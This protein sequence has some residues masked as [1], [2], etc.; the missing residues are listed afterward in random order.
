MIPKRWRALITGRW[1]GSATLVPAATLTVQTNVLGPTPEILAYNAAH[2][3]PD[4]NTRDWWRYAGVNGA[5]IFMSPNEVEATDDLA[6]VGDGVT[7][8][9]TFLARKAALRADPL[10]TSY[11]NWPYFTNRYEVND[12]YPNNHIKIN[13]AFTELRKLGIQIC[14]QITASE[15]RLPIADANDWGGKWELWQHYYAQAFYLGREFDVQRFQMFNEPNHPNAGGLTAENHLMRLQL[16]ADAVQSALAD[17]NSRYGKSLL[18]QVLAPVSAGNATS[19]YPGWG[20]TVVT[21]RHLNFLGVT[22]PN[23]WLIQTYDYHQYGSTPAAFGSNLADLHAL[24]AADMTPEPR[25]PTAISEFNTRT[26]ASYDSIP[27][28]LD[29][30]AEYARFGAIA[31]NLMANG[32]A[33]MYA[34]KFGQTLSSYTNYPVQKNAMHYIDNNNA[35]YNTGGITKAGEVYRLFNKAFAAGRRRLNTIK[36]SGASGLDVHA[37]FDPVRNCYHLFSANNTSSALALNLSLA[38]LNLP[39]TNRVLLEEVSEKSYGSG[40]LWT[41]VSGAE[42]GL[43]TQPAYSVWL[44]TLPLTAQLAEQIVPATDDAEVRDGANKANNYGALTT[45][46][47]RN[48]PADTANRSVAFFK[49]QLPTNSLSDLQFAELSLQAASAGVNTTAQSHVYALTNT[50]WS[51]GGINWNNAPNLKGNVA[52]GNTIAHRFVTGQGTNASI[53]GQLVTTSTV[54]SEK[55]IDVTDY[56]RGQSNNTVAFLVS[57]DPRWDVALPS[58][59]TGDT[60]PAGVK[61]ITTEGGNGPRLRLVFAAPAPNELPVALNDCAATSRNIPVNINVLANDRDLDGGMLAIQSFT[62]GAFGSVSNA[63]SGV[64]TY[65]PDNGFTGLDAFSYTVNDGQGGAA[66]AAVNVTVNA[67]DGS[68][69]LVVT[70]LPVAIEANIQGGASAETD[71]NEV[72][73]GYLMLKY[74]AAPFDSARKVYFQ[75]D[76]TGLNVQVTNAATFSVTTHTMTF[77]QRAQLWGLNQ[78]YPGFNSSLTWNLAQANETNSNALL[79]NGV[80]HAS[81]IGDSVL[82]SGATSTVRSFTIPRLGD[83]LVGNHVT[84]ILSGVEDAGNASGGL[85]L[86]RNSARLQ[87]ATAVPA[88]NTSP[89]A[90]NDQFSTRE[91]TALSVAA[92]G[93][94]A[95]DTD[96]E[97]NALTAIL[98]SPPEQG[99]LTLSANGAF[100]YTPASGFFGNDSFA[101]KVSDGWVDSNIATVSLGV[102]PGG[103]RT[104]QIS[105]ISSSANGNIAIAF[106]GVP[107]ATYIVQATTNL[108]SSGWINLST[109]VAG[110]DGVWTFIDAGATQFQA[111][112]YRSFAP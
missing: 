5:R 58:L 4:S 20:D 69:I 18:A 15:G 12:L 34:F 42:A 53:V 106:L 40:A 91:N 67:G 43:G 100:V 28:T 10:N 29:Y 111:Q 31:V 56:L 39:P 24:L 13:Y 80:L 11:I 32:I 76:L 94:L 26:G 21:N 17:V 7:N 93:V 2:F 30:P 1:L 83:F 68:E 45:M 89:V 66:T 104:N 92:P 23:F 74:Y 101:Y 108:A 97:T 19:A 47:A 61:I 49:F 22:D 72:T 63:G 85:R 50:A 107:G 77:A 37:S 95:N 96:A 57:Q 99:L 36:D 8:Q 60:Q 48:D 84:L 54:A 112:Y 110:P 65:R 9:S 79:T 27:D 102:L 38:A 62:P 44:L 14:A 78:S 64:L 109:N 98:V 82:I 25:F 41:T 70:N 87:V 88:P 71:V 35:P 52:A 55:L 59:D 86:A 51:Q 3:F 75:F 103:F 6:P 33:E 46:T 73:Q 81:A 105:G 16:V 90:V